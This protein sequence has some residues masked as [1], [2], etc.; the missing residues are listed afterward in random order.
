ML[1]LITD[2]TW[3]GSGAPGKNWAG[4]PYDDS[5]WSAGRKPRE[6]ERGDGRPA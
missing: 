2:A 5:K 3:K 4:L 1:P 6:I